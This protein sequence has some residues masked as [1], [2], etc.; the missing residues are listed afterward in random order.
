MARISVKWTQQTNLGVQIVELGGYSTQR[1]VKWYVDDV[2]WVTDDRLISTSATTSF[3]STLSGLKPGTTYRI[4]AILY[5][6]YN[7]SINWTFTTTATTNRPSDTTPPGISNIWC[8]HNN[9]TNEDYITISASI[10]D[11]SSISSTNLLFNSKNYSH[12]SVSGNTYSYRV[13]TPSIFG[14]YDIDIS[15]RDSANNV[16][17]GTSKTRVGLDKTP[18]TIAFSEAK[19]MGGGIRTGANATDNA[20]GSGVDYL[21]FKI[22]SKN[23]NTDFSSAVGVEGNSAYHTFTKDKNG[24][25]FELGASY[26]VEITAK[27]LAGNYSAKTVIKVI[28]SIQRPDTFN[29]TEYEREAF[30][31]R[32]AI[33]TLTWQRWNAFLDNVKGTASWYHNK[34]EDIYNVES[35]KMTDSS[36]ILTAIRFNTVKNAI[37]SMNSTGISDKVK[38]D[39]VIGNEF[40]TLSL[41]LSE[42]R[43]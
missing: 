43:K 35:A 22:S 1:K 9:W 28:P 16:G 40:I 19:Y 20:G 29:W 23:S 12:S 33:T 2:L 7:S 30:T 34:N 14:Y 41:K 31:N 5:H 6:A 39:F 38:G 37:G 11:A 4:K 8:S 36:K 26:Y 24:Y 42:I 13:P 3:E 27:D 32:G 25:D 18:P 17:Y 21:Y 10:T 15:A